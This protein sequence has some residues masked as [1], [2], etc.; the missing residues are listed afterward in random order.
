MSSY[1]EQIVSASSDL[2][3]KALGQFDRIVDKAADK[4]D[5]FNRSMDPIA[6]APTDDALQAE[7]DE[8]LRPALARSFPE[9]QKQFAENNEYSRVEDGLPAELIDRIRR[10]V[11]VDHATRSVWPWHRAAG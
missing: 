4:L 8:L 1:P 7:V 3:R 5:A 11:I 6:G 10:E 2:R 9:V